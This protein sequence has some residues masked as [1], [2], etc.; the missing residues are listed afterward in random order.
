MIHKIEA[1]QK[2]AVCSKSF[3]STKKKKKRNEQ[4]SSSIFADFLKLWFFLN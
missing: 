1:T 4:K 2:A 3:L